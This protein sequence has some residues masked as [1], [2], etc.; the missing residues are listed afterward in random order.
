MIGEDSESGGSNDQSR[1]LEEVA[2]MYPSNPRVDGDSSC[3]RWPLQLDYCTAVYAG[4][5]RQPLVEILGRN[6][7][8]N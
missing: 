2:S 8:G 1:R 6:S 5:R 3:G 7:R 4:N